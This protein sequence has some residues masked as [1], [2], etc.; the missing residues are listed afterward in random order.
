[1]LHLYGLKTCDTCRKAM[2][3][4]GAAGIAYDFHDVRAD[5]LTK[6]QL[7]GWADAVGWEA[8]LNKSSATWRGLADADKEDLN[9]QKAIALIAAHPALM[10]RPLIERDGTEVYVGW[11]KDVCDALD[12]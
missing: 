9:R 12:V 6:K 2:K 4:L 5:G 3:A 1:M 8:L 10:K 7:A 11:T